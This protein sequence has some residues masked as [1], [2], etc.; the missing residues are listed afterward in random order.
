MR[1]DSPLCLPAR[2]AGD[3]AVEPIL[4]QQN[5]QQHHLYQ[6]GN[7]RT[8]IKRKRLS[9]EWDQQQSVDEKDA[10]AENGPKDAAFSP[11]H[12]AHHA[13]GYGHRT[14]RDVAVNFKSHSFSPL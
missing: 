12:L 8:G 13:G 6:Q 11:H 10:P 14:I 9:V 3:H 7:H 5:G 1:H 4:K 2:F